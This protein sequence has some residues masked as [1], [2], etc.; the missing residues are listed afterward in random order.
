MDFGKNMQHSP[1]GKAYLVAQGDTR[2]IVQ[3][4]YAASDQAFLVRVK[5]SPGTMNDPQAYE[6]FGGHDKV[7]KP[8]WTS[9]FAKIKPLFEWNDHMGCVT[10]T[11]NSPLKKY[12][13]WVTDTR[14]P[15]NDC[16]GAF[17]SYLLES[18]E[19]TGPWKMVV[20]L[21]HFGDQAYFVNFPSR[22]ISD[23]GRTVW[24]CFSA[25]WEPKAKQNLAGSS[26]ALCLREIRL[27]ATP[28]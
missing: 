11:Y 26:Y 15:N 6:Y 24:M 21:K 10:M 27:V 8:L 18:S 5:P 14:G 3:T 7:G 22:F 16:A 2:P 23:D 12:L 9:D 25:Q 28:K 1:D 4:A 19:I 20:Y 17:N 13:V